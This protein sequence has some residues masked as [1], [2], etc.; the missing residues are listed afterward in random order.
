LKEGSACIAAEMSVKSSE[1]VEHERTNLAKSASTR[2]AHF[3][4]KTK[5]EYYENRC[6]LHTLAIIIY[7]LHRCIKY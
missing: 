6:Y 5:D 7:A 2:S 4:V 1:L 3:L